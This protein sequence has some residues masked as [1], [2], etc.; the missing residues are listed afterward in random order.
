MDDGV[1]ALGRQQQVNTRGCSLVFVEVVE[2]L[3]DGLLVAVLNVLEFLASEGGTMLDDLSRLSIGIF[4][5]VW[6]FLS[7]ST[8]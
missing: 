4:S 5:K 7:P 1:D 3:V 8:Y 6:S 2:D